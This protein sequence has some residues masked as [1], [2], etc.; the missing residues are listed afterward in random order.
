M[1]GSFREK[2]LIWPVIVVALLLTSVGGMATVVFFA[3]SDGGAQ[4][5]DQYYEKAVAWDSLSAMNQAYRKKKWTAVLTVEN[6]NGSL[7][8]QDSLRIRVTDLTGI[9]NLTRPQ[10]AS[11]GV[12][13]SLEYEPEDTSYAFSHGSLASGLWDYNFQVE[14]GETGFSFSVR[15]EIR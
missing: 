15:K 7:I 4:V 6:G 5:I 1:A 12:Q 13:Y 3:R 8:V 11:E 9:V 14:S 10:S 2:G